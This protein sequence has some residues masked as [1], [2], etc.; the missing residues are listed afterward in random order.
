MT[1]E[2]AIKHSEEIAATN[3]DGYREEH[4]QLAA[5]LK[6]LKKI[7]EESIVIPN[8]GKP[9]EIAQIFINAKRTVRDTR[10]MGSYRTKT[11]NA[12]KKSEIKAIGKHLLGYAETEQELEQAK[13]CK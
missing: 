8:N 2:E 7:K 3:C 4:E 13:S 11:I 10:Y 1:Y 6:E 12:F 9:W 5:L